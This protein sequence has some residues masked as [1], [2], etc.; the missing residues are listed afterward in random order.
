MIKRTKLKMLASIIFG[1]LWSA[2][3]AASQAPALGK[4]FAEIVKL[5]AKEGKVRVGSGLTAEEAPLLVQRLQPKVPDDQS[6]CDAGERHG[7]SG[8]DL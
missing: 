7:S 4:N 1:V 8:A 2:G 3:Q 6:R 5:A